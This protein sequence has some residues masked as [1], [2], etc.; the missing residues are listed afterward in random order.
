MSKKIRRIVCAGVL[1]ALYF[2]LTSLQNLI[3]PGSA[4]MAIQFRFSEALSVFAFFTPAAIPGLAL[5]CMIFNLSWAQSLPLDF[6]LGPIA[7]ALSCICMRLLRKALWRKLPV[8]GLLMPAV[9]NGIVVGW[10]LTVFL[11]PHG[12][13][14]ALY[15]LNALY[16]VIGEAAVLLT[17]GSV[18]YGA[19]S[20]R[21]LEQRL[22]GEAA[23]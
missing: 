14:W 6:L 16:V 19:M 7:T 11:S 9:F 17:C 1:A 18:L 12:F 2:T 23:G 20:R 13:S 22:L 15:G 21:G 10:E 4:T 5:G 8:L 3:W